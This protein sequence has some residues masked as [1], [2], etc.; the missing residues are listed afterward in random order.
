[1]SAVFTSYAGRARTRPHKTSNI[2]ACEMTSAKVHRPN[3][4]QG[5][6][7]KEVSGL[8]EEMSATVIQA[9]WRGEASRRDGK[10]KKTSLLA[11]LS[12]SVTAPV[13]AALA[14]AKAAAQLVGMQMHLVGQMQP[15]HNGMAKA[16]AISEDLRT[17]MGQAKQALE[18]HLEFPFLASDTHPMHGLQDWSAAEW[19]MQMQKTPELSALLAQSL[20]N[21][22]DGST[23]YDPCELALQ[24]CQF[25]KAPHRPAPSRASVLLFGGTSETCPR[26]SRMPHCHTV[27][28]L[29]CRS[30]RRSGRRSLFRSGAR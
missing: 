5:G 29:A 15:L 1:M 24:V 4:A 7:M 8:E 23:R 19:A 20:L 6:S 13:K 22:G 27:P 3:A 18:N 14:P 9:R 25:T 30:R 26:L 17:D 28:Y 12:V 2:N 21:V 16:A 11:S 10:G